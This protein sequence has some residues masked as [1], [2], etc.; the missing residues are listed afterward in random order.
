MEFTNDWQNGLWS[1]WGYFT[2]LTEIKSNLE[3]PIFIKVNKSAISISPRK[4]VMPIVSFELLA[5]KWLCG[6]K[7]I[8]SPQDYEKYSVNS[9]RLGKTMRN[10]NLFI[11]NIK[12]N[13]NFCS[14]FED[15]SNKEFIIC[16]YNTK[17]FSSFE[18][19][20][21]RNYEVKLKGLSILAPLP[22]NSI[23][24]MLV[25]DGNIYFN[26][27]VQFLSDQARLFARPDSA[28][29]VVYSNLDSINGESCQILVRQFNIPE[30]ILK[31]PI[32]HF[33]HTIEGGHCCLTFK[34][35]ERLIYMCSLNKQC[36]KII[37]RVA[38]RIHLQCEK[39]K[40]PN[41]LE[42]GT[43]IN[44]NSEIYDKHQIGYWAGY[45]KYAQLGIET[46]RK[47]MYVVVDGIK[48][49]ITI[50][51]YSKSNE[52]RQIFDI[53]K[54]EWVCDSEL[55]CGPDEFISRKNDSSLKRMIDRSY[56][57]LNIDSN[58]HCTSLE[59]RTT[60][61]YFS[62]KIV[63]LFCP[64]DKTQGSSFRMAI[65]NAYD[66]IIEKTDINNI[67]FAP[68]GSEYSIYYYDLDNS[69]NNLTAIK[70]RLTPTQIEKIPDEVSLLSYHDMKE[71]AN[72]KCGLEFRNL[73]LPP[74]LIEMNQNP[75]CCFTLMKNKDKVL[76]CSAA[77]I[78]CVTES[79]MMMKRIKEDCM[80]VMSIDRQ[81]SSDDLKEISE[82]FELA[83]QNSNIPEILGPVKTND[84]TLKFDLEK[85]LWEGVVFMS[86]LDNKDQI[87]F[88]RKF[89]KLED[90]FIQV[91]QSHE[92]RNNSYLTEKF[93][94]F[95]VFFSC[96]SPDL[97]HPSDYVSQMAKVRSQYE[98]QWLK[99][100]IE[101]FM[102]KLPETTEESNC[103][104]IEFEEPFFHALK[105]Y[106]ICTKDQNQGFFL[107]KIISCRYVERVT[108][109]DL[110]GSQAINLPSIS[111]KDKYNLRIYEE[112]TEES[113]SYSTSKFYLFYHFL[114][115]YVFELK[116]LN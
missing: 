25:S 71:I 110:N 67:P 17:Q 40:N 82:N 109:M 54:L 90:D 97:C 79:R 5:L 33:N 107:R 42:T 55:P 111:Q 45:V 64:F 37:E 24:P 106:I 30:Q 6:S 60:V 76:I 75:Q 29:I 87:D 12:L 46:P 52:I 92:T 68:E 84:P 83:D 114:I 93:H 81:V 23:L 94:I 72:V 115:F 3:S 48:K 47:P 96:N 78:R 41:D 9:E 21:L 112:N 1:G 16:I 2:F 43:E 63:A 100:A 101:N 105:P 13:S 8:C 104:V 36:E 56:L 14:V 39:A 34:Y 91:S 28:P 65:K 88:Q 62:K 85:N 99:A 49:T 32:D 22:E 53:V 7:K 20:M 31:Y 61:F 103:F 10:A 66:Q 51:S 69:D 59:I 108:L 89:L 44:F 19:T 11:D 116:N 27:P 18:K 4:T 102:V 57:E 35:N 86:T 80:T 58:F 113:S 73:T 70:A 95:T 50:R 98:I 26:E 77:A 15:Y 74:R 38:K